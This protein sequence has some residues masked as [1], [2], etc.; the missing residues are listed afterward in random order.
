MPMRPEGLVIWRA[1]PGTIVRPKICGCPLGGSGDGLPALMF[2][3][4][5]EFERLN[6]LIEWPTIDTHSGIEVE[7]RSSV[8]ALVLGD[9]EP[10]LEIILYGQQVQASRWQPTG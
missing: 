8:G 4:A 9:D 6:K 2:D 10:D 1:P 7:L 5:G 3:P